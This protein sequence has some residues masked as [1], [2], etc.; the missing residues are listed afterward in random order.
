VVRPAQEPGGFQEVGPDLSGGVR[1][2]GWLLRHGDRLLET[3][4]KR[5]KDEG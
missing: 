5:M 1:T 4:G 3:E 2:W